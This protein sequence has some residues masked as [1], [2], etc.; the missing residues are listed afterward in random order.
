MTG[1]VRKP[2][3]RALD[4]AQSRLLEAAAG[5]ASAA[6]APSHAAGASAA[7]AA[8]VKRKGRAV[9]AK[10]RTAVAKDQARASAQAT[11]EDAESEESDQQQPRPDDDQP[12][13]TL[14]CV[15]LG[16]DTGEQPMIQ[17]EHCTNWFHFGCIGLTEDVA[18]R[19]EGFAC[20][21]CQQMGVGTTRML[22][23]A[24]TSSKTLDNDLAATD[25]E[26]Q[27]A[28]D[29]AQAGDD[30]EEEEDS[31]IDNND[32]DDPMGEDDDED[33]RSTGVERKRRRGKQALSRDGRAAR[34]RRVKVEV[35]SEVDSDSFDEDEDEDAPRSR[36]KKK[37][38]PNRRTSGTPARPPLNT[39]DSKAAAVPQTEKTRA[40]VVKQFTATFSSI[41]SA[42]STSDAEDVSHR[43]ASFAQAV[44]EELF[45]GYYEHDDKGV[46]APKA[47]YT[48]KFRSLQFNLKTNAVFRSRIAHDEFDAAGIVNISAEDLQTPE[49]KA[50]AESIRAAS[51]KN[52]VKE[53]LVAP[54]AKRTHKGEEEMEN[55][56]ARLMAE[57][58]AALK[59]MERKKAAERKARERSDSAPVAESPFP[60]ESRSGGGGRT[61]G[62]S[63]APGTPDV[64]GDVSSDPFS[65]SRHRSSL[66]EAHESHTPEAGQS[67]SVKQGSPFGADSPFRPGRSGSPVVPD[68][69]QGGA[70]SPPPQPRQRNSSATV[71]MSAIWGKAKAASPSLEPAEP[72]G[73]PAAAAR[74]DD[75]GPHGFESD[76]FDF[77]ASKAGNDDDDD[78]FEQGLFRSEGASPVKKTPRPPTQ[79]PPRVPAISELPPVWAGDLIVTEE[80]GFPAYGVQIGGRPV[81][82]DSKTW[83][84]LLPRS[85]TTAG[86]ISTHQASKYLVDCS[87][88]PT[89][90]LN[91]VALLP[92]ATGPSEL[93]PNKP[94]GDRCLAKHSHIF[95][96]YL[97]KDR[98]GV[99][100]APKELSALV[101]DIYIIPLPK[102]H[103][104]PEYVELL[105]EHV[106]PE[107]GKRDQNLLLCVLVLQKG[108]LPTIRTKALAPSPAPTPVPSSHSASGSTPS[109]ASTA[110]HPPPPREHL[111]TPPNAAARPLDPAAFQS[112]LSN[113][114]PT[115]L[116]SLLSNPQ[117]LSALT[118]SQSQAVLNVANSQPSLPLSVPTGPR[119][120]RTGGGGGGGGPPIHPSRLAQVAV[121]PNSYA[122]GVGIPPPTG[123]SR[124]PSSSSG[125]GGGGGY[126]SQGQHFENNLTNQGEYNQEQFGAM[127]DGGWVNNPHVRHG[128]PAG[129]GGG[130]GGPRGG[131]HHGGGHFRGGGGGGGTPRT[132]G[133][134]GRGGRGGFG[135]P[136]GN[137]GYG[138]YGRGGGGY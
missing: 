12:D 108:V 82:V 18:T 41:Y 86:R 134:G 6:A 10:G 81:G 21:M 22:P 79:P 107:T 113:V 124:T 96:Y 26:E 11:E 103:P 44:E 8:A 31:G 13:L 87:F 77:T 49:L 35:D 120:D 16:Y 33:Y 117:T 102:D 73:D 15:C 84:K 7:N 61:F 5:R 50:M 85:L 105:D 128:V 119:A 122:G 64:G 69:G 51:L 1:R 130:G 132:G 55:N 91:V 97:H 17:C 88:A 114:D 63:P 78:D 94:T 48:S 65:R 75:D 9:N 47:K 56:S 71:D 29:D 67:P 133:G 66:A 95:D 27:Y 90:E 111:A 39:G 38:A 20:E 34:R 3:A 115:T 52:S 43:S 138:G 70:M 99:V 62:G 59:E 83:Q 131:Y 118:T 127:G 25:P 68:E 89:R 24:S 100:Q 23:N 110:A 126:N 121:D 135:T 101:K 54:T 2:T 53:A 106:V 45:S 60:D 112:L 19:I 136:R 80:G 92:D 30:D 72:E 57:E 116:Q 125:G 37:P 93:F 40:A 129:G 36:T 74:A 32:D 123:P 137:H 4:A 104:L 58:E 109:M 28:D 46:R 42:S 98:I 76:M 14:Y